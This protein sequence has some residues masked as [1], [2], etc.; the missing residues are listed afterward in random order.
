MTARILMILL[1]CCWRASLVGSPA[2]DLDSVSQEVRDAAAKI[3]RASYT[4]PSRTNWDAV[5]SA[6]TNGMTKTHVLALLSPYNVTSLWGDA[7]GGSHSESY[8]LDDAWILICW[9]R[10]S[11]KTSEWGD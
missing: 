1:I 2:S 3:L 11:P 5:V 8:R 9:F 4:P 10:T 7:T 6:I